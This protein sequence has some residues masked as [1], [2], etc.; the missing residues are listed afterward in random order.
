MD[1][2]LRIPEGMLSLLILPNVVEPGMGRELKFWEL[3]FCLKIRKQEGQEKK[4][5]LVMP[6]I[7]QMFVAQ[8]LSLCLFSSFSCW[9]EMGK[10][11]LKMKVQED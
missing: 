7:E 11:E 5:I 4:A 3:R 8:S 10:K 6:F 2:C 1:A 9:E